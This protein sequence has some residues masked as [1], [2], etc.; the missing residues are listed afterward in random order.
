MD[1]L[2]GIQRQSPE[3]WHH[4]FRG[5]ADC[6]EQIQRLETEFKTCAHRLTEMETRN[7]IP[8]SCA[9]SMTEH[10]KRLSDMRAVD[11]ALRKIGSAQAAMDL[12]LARD[13]YA[14]SRIG[15]TSEGRQTSMSEA[16]SNGASRPGNVN[17]TVLVKMTGGLS[18]SNST[19]GG[20]Y[21]IRR[22]RNGDIYKGRYQ[23]GKK[24]GEGVYQFVNG[25]VYEGEFLA[26]RMA[27]NGVYTFANE[28]R[29]EGQ[30]NNCVYDG[31]GNETFARGSTYRG[32]Y[33][34]GMRDGW[35]ACRY[36]NGD[37]YEGQWK[38]G[39][40]EGRG[41]QQCTEESNYIGD[42]LAGKRHGYGYYCFPNSDRYLGEYECDIPH[43]YG[44]YIFATGQKYEG[45]WVQGKKHGWCI[46]TI[47]TGKNAEG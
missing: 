40:R 11:G 21:Q 7:P 24:N 15:R 28:G 45:Q 46:Y 6:V 13:S 20:D 43:G 2:E 30:W 5:F 37:Y 31:A 29:Y 19:Q 35:G 38:H 3:E 41:M 44:I 22:L 26:D 14:P 18:S 32:E 23:G 27:G 36:Y 42:Y 39:L 47:E 17:E 10:Q 34:N 12:A 25:D 16:S 9:L 33:T 4:A 1:N 8:T